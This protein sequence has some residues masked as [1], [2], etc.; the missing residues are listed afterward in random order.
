VSVVPKLRVVTDP[1][2]EVEIRDRL[3]REAVRF[4]TT[5]SDIENGGKQW[6]HTGRARRLLAA[7]VAYLDVMGQSDE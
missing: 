6:V 2:R 3:L 7:A 1:A 4:A 5:V